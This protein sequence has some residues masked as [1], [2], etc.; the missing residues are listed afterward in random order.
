[1][2]SQNLVLSYLGY[3]H[4]SSPCFP[5]QGGFFL[6]KH[7]SYVT[8]LKPFIAPHRFQDKAKNA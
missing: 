4:F 6:N 3:Y 1:M 7:I 5:L 2:F 8:D